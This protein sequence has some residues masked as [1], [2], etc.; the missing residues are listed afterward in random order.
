M[1]TTPLLGKLLAAVAVFA[2]AVT[3][4]QLRRVSHD[5]AP[6]GTMLALVLA[7]TLVIVPTFAALQSGAS[8]AGSISDRQLRAITYGGKAGEAAPRSCSARWWFAGLG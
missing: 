7:V 6:F 8:A 5:S 4:W 3:G 2:V 1:L